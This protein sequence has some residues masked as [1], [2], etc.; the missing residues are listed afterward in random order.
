MMWTRTKTL[1]S[2]ILGIMEFLLIQSKICHIFHYHVN[3]ISKLMT[4]FVTELVEIV[5]FLAYS[6]I[7]VF[8]P[9]GV[10]VFSLQIICSH[11]IFMQ[12]QFWFCFVILVKMFCKFA[13]AWPVFDVVAMSGEAPWKLC[14]CMS[15]I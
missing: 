2:Y 14:P 9:C 6:P 5:L 8:K 11:D 1:N 7:S 4:E 3:M 10:K 15:N 13:A 12:L